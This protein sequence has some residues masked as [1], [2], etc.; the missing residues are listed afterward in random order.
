MNSWHP[1]FDFFVDQAPLPTNYY[2][3]VG[4]DG[5][6]REVASFPALAQLVD[7]ETSCGPHECTGGQIMDDGTMI[8]TW[9]ENSEPGH[10]GISCV[11]E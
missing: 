9:D 11:D 7:E 4:I 10:A 8:M 5:Y 2:K 6:D 1:I 3:V